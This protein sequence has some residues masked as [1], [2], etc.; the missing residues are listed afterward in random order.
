V[1]VS[2]S[3]GTPRYTSPEQLVAA[4]RTA[5]AL[6]SGVPLSKLRYM[7]PE[8]LLGSPVDQRS[9]MFAFSAIVHEMLTGA[10]A[11]DRGTLDT[12]M[13]IM[14]SDPR[15]PSAA[16]VPGFARIGEACLNEAPESRPSA[17]DVVVTL[18]DLRSEPAG[19]DEVVV[20]ATP[21]GAG[22]DTA[23]SV[24][25]SARRSASHSARRRVR[26]DSR[27]FVGVVGAL[28]AAVGFWLLRVT[29]SAERRAS[30]ATSLAAPTSTTSQK[31]PT[32]SQVVS[33]SMP[34][35]APLVSPTSAFPPRGS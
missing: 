7:S 29:E 1:L 3:L 31:T 28:A 9:D 13:A 8:Q 6:A 10:P 32:T 30:T 5:S 21:S 19:P 18:R 23:H 15:Q 4:T 16:D 33:P 34:S 11:F 14:E 27:R 2:V 20:S 24:D 26:H 25:H 12:M 22:Q 35:E 17:K